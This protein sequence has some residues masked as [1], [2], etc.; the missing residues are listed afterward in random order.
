MASIQNKT[1]QMR[2]KGKGPL[3]AKALVKTYA[4]L[5][6]PAT[7]TVD[8]TLIAYNGMIT[9]VWLDKTVD[10]N[11][12][13]RN[14]IYYFFDPTVTSIINQSKAKVNEPANWHRLGG[15]DSLPGLQ[16]QL[17]A[18]QEKLDAV[19]KD[20]KELQDSATVVK[21]WKTDFPEIGIAGK[22]YVATKEATTYVWYNN[23]YLTVGD[24]SG[25]DIEIQIISGGG[26]TA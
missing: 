10:D 25:D 3:D 26:P 21:E 7:W 13:S 20:V 17:N 15:I 8:G 1:D 12:N 2:F 4:E 9:A 22:I 18:L 19:K 11:G 23:E 6:D 14:G 5:T 24:G 16:E